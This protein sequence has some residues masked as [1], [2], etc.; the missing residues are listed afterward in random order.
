VS[1]VVVVVVGRGDGTARALVLANGPVLEVVVA[2]IDQADLVIATIAVKSSHCGAA[3]ARIVGAVV[4]E[5]LPR[6]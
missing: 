5:N 3:T 6:C 1:I 2:T 4:L